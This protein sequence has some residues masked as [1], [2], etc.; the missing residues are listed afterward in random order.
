[1]PGKRPG[2]TKPPETGRKWDGER[3]GQGVRFRARHFCV[4]PT[5]IARRLRQRSIAFKQKRLLSGK[6]VAVTAVS[7]KVRFP[8]SSFY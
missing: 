1:M 6:H 8:L 7:P 2:E 4:Y 5:T 3:A